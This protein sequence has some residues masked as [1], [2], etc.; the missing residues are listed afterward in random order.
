[1]ADRRPAS[2]KPKGSGNPNRI[3]R[4]LSGVVQKAYS[5][6]SNLIV[7]TNKG[8]NSEQNTE[9]RGSL[10]GKGIKL[11]VV[12]NRLTLR[13]FLDMGVTEAEKL[14]VGQTAIIEAE[15]PVAAAKLALEFCK[16]FEDKLVVV[17]GLVEGKVLN[18]TEVKALSKAKSKPETMSEIAGL[19][20]GPGG[21]L[22]AAINGLG[23]T[24]AGQLKTLTERL[25]K[26]EPASTPA[27]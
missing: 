24:I 4:M 17:G 3:N 9:L 7:L 6:T 8:L 20:R 15:D 21:K 19:I 18:A 22:A 27:A 11:K 2:E 1:M 12:R 5:T 16:K 13:A 10:R 14:F 26:G 23:S 25:E